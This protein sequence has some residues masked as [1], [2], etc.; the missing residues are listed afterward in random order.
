MPMAVRVQTADFDV[1]R[2]LAALRAGDARVGAAVTFVG[3][4]RDMN[5]D[6]RV[7]QM[8]LE[9][10]PGI[11]EQSLDGIIV[12]AKG[13]FDIYDALVIHRVGPLA[14]TD[15]IVFVAVTS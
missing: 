11:T 7:T 1:G 8:T 14:P 10:S 3:T 12:K 5:D 15:Q 6:A 13:R 9:H 2:E 4:V